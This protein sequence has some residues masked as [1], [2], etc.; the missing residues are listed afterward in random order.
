MSRTDPAPRLL[1]RPAESLTESP[2]E[3][4]ARRRAGSASPGKPG[5][6]GIGGKDWGPPDP[7]GHW[8]DATRVDMLLW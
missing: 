4:P 1:G 8:K 2:A 5:L 7:T 6:R 3:T